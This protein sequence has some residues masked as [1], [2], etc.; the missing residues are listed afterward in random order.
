MVSYHRIVDTHRQCDAK[1]VLPRVIGSHFAP[2]MIA[3]YL[4]YHLD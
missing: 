4:T 1:C 2:L 3:I